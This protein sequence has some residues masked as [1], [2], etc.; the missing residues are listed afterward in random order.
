M[1]INTNSDVAGNGAPVEPRKIQRTMPEPDVAAFTKLGKLTQSLA[2][3]P[4]IRADQV[5]RAK[6]LIADPTYPSQT[7][8]RR[9]AD[10]LTQKLATPGT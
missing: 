4:D 3:V 5:A 7:D 2:N 10:L 1:R 9:L 6:A 8:T